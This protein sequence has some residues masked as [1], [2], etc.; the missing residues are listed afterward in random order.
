MLRRK[1]DLEEVLV[2]RLPLIQKVE[3]L[4]ASGSY[5]RRRGSLI[6]AL[7]RNTKIRNLLLITM[8]K[9]LLRAYIHRI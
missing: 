2:T 4:K 5:T 6:K 3:I 1:V 9:G 7:K 8:M